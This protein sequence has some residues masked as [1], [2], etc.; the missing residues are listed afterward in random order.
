[1]AIWHFKMYL[2]PEAEL[3]QLCGGVPD[4]LG[5]EPFEAGHWRRNNNDLPT[6]KGC[7]NH[8]WGNADLRGDGILS[9]RQGAHSINVY[10]DPKSSSVEAIAAVAD[11]RE[12]H[13]VFFGL[14]VQACRELNC[15]LHLSS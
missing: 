2:V 7:L 5:F 1:M 14:V 6:V 9:W 15:L 3:V 10:F 13:A 11:A 12:A 8:L 4:S